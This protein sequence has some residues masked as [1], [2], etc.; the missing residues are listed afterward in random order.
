[1]RYP[2]GPALVQAGVRREF[3]SPELLTRAGARVGGCNRR[4][5]RSGAP[6]AR[7]ASAQ[8]R[9]R[10]APGM[11]ERRRTRGGSSSAV[12]TGIAAVVDCR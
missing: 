7:G 12:T 9:A 3:D 4:G 8:R 11:G 5:G 10:L 6:P 1:M 2:V